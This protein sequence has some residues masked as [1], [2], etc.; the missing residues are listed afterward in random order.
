[1]ERADA[2]ETSRKVPARTEALI[3]AI[4]TVHAALRERKLGCTTRALR[5]AAKAAQ[6]PADEL[7]DALAAL[8]LA[9]RATYAGDRARTLRLSDETLASFIISRLYENP[10]GCTADELLE[11]AQKEGLPLDAVRDALVSQ[12]V[13]DRFVVTDDGRLK[14]QVQGPPAKTLDFQRAE[15]GTAHERYYEE[16]APST[17]GYWSDGYR[18]EFTKD[19]ERIVYSSAFR[20]L[21]GVTQVFGTSEGHTFH[22]RLTHSIKAAQ[23]ARSIA[24]QPSLRD[25]VDADVVEAAAL[26]HDLGHPPF[27]HAGESELDALL[28]T[29]GVPDGYEGNAQNLRIVTQLS[30]VRSEFRGLNLT[31]ATLN[32][33]MKYPWLRD[34]DEKS[35]KHKKWNVYS[36][37]QRFFDFARSRSEGERK[38]PSAQVME[39]ADDIAYGVHDIEDAV[40]AGM[41]PLSELLNDAGERDRFLEGSREWWGDKDGFANNKEDAERALKILLILAQSDL[42]RPFIDDPAQR[43]ALRQLT[44]VLHHRYI[45]AVQ[46]QDD[47]LC[48]RAEYAREVTILNCLM[49]FYVFCNPMLLPQQHGQREVVRALF[50]YYFDAAQTATGRNTLPPAVRE[51]FEDDDNLDMQSRSARAA[52]DTVAGMTELEAVA[53]FSM[54]TGFDA[55]RITNRGVY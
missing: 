9:D 34:R 12:R 35:K 15:P 32:A 29:H 4:E 49:R 30:R 23:I 27:G 48:F 24:R 46:V 55:G 17:Y 28:T 39:W 51:L 37:E 25:K 26:A 42:R 22:N 44:T 21:G 52:A 13:R 3:N 10:L 8:L 16:A 7:T 50:G 31:R 19:H 36:T 14:S 45:L 33:L 53:T 40:R 54:L 2:H 5:E 6:I 20:R 38:S 11:G 18:S 1:M 47:E 41:I 43:A